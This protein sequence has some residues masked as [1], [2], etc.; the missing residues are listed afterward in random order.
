MKTSNQSGKYLF[1]GL[2]SGMVILSMF[3]SSCAKDDT[4]LTINGTVKVKIVNAASGSAAQD[5]YLDNTKINSEAVAYSESTSYI[6]ANA[7]NRK[8]EFRNSGSTSANF[9]GNVDL[10]P[11]EHYTFFYTGK[12][13]GSGNSSAVFKDEQTSPSANKAKLRFVN[14]AEGFASA[15]LLVT[16]GVTLA[17][18]IAF[19]TASNFSEVDPGILTLQTTLAAGATGST[20]LGAFTLVAGKI[21]TIYTSGSLTGSGQTAVSANILV[22]N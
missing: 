10:V 13:D 7:G 5:F 16:G 17:S 4:E 6:S 9:T 8:G 3:I 11:N 21:Y 19:G 20:N 22:H 18:N 2:M 1:S 14:L 12:A 15:N